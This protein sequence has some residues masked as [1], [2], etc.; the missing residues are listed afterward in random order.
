MKYLMNHNHESLRGY[1]DPVG[2]SRYTYVDVESRR[3]TKGAPFEAGLNDAQG[4]YANYR[5]RLFFIAEKV[6]A[7]TTDPL[8]SRSLGRARPLHAATN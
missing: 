1:G 5:D 7:C 8:S 6:R 3:R 2:R 4:N